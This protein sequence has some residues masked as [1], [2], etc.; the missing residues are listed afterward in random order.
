MA[1]LLY[2]AAAESHLH[3]ETRSFS[4]LGGLLSQSDS[5]AKFMRSL[6]HNNNAGRRKGRWGWIV[7]GLSG[8][9]ERQILW[10]SRQDFTQTTFSLLEKVAGTQSFILVRVV[11]I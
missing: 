3:F 7:A 2:F 6:A 1:P 5:G 9:R 4:P 10:D 11:K 8:E